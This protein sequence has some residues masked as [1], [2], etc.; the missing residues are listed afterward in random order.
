M[1]QFS[2]GANMRAIQLGGDRFC[3][4]IHSTKN[5]AIEPV[6]AGQWR[7]VISRFTYEDADLSDVAGRQNNGGEKTPSPPSSQRARSNAGHFALRRADWNLAGR[8]A[9]S[10]LGFLG[11]ARAVLRPFLSS[12]VRRHVEVDRRWRRVADVAR[13]AQ[14]RGMRRMRPLAGS[15]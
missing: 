12:P 14:N 9:F 15:G 8:W 6:F 10:A 3:S 13:S 1:A 4:T 11:V 5:C 7:I 2:V